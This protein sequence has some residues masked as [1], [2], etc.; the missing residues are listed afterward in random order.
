MVLALY[1]ILVCIY[2]RWISRITHQI[3]SNF[4]H[5]SLLNTITISTVSK[6]SLLCIEIR[7]RRLV[8]IARYRYIESY[9]PVSLSCS[10]ASSC[11][12]RFCNSKLRKRLN[13]MRR[14]CMGRNFCGLLM[15][16]F[17]RSHRLF[18]LVKVLEIIHS[19]LRGGIVG[20]LLCS[21]FMIHVLLRGEQMGVKINHLQATHRP[22]YWLI[23]RSNAMHLVFLALSFITSSWTS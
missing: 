12:N 8:I 20:R 4:P 13:F 21:S 22:I 2:K 23:K 14:W 15:A 9:W 6:E 5:R 3:F 19:Q 16:W 11:C 7:I 17:W 10:S 1:R 18:V